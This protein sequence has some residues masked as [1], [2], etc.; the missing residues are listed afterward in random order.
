MVA[1]L[2]GW[3]LPASVG[4]FKFRLPAGRPIEQQGLLRRQPQGRCN[5]LRSGDN[6]ARSGN[7]AEAIEIYQRVIQQF[8]DKV[9][10]VPLE[11]RGAVEE[12]DSGSR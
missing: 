9:V 5:D 6:H 11:A 4:Q 8:G 2:V 10:E 1:L 7:Y 12:P 3:C